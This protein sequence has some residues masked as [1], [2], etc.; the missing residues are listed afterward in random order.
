MGVSAAATCAGLVR[1]VG[2][3]LTLSSCIIVLAIT[4]VPHHT[5]YSQDIDR[6][7]E[8][9]DLGFTNP[10]NV[11]ARPAGMAG[12]YVAAGN[13]VHMLV[14]NPAGLARIKRIELSLGLQQQRSSIALQYYGNPNSIDVRDGGMDGASLAW[15]LP[16]YQGSFTLAFGVYRVYSSVFDLHY[17][18]VNQSTKTFDNYLV[19]QMGSIYSYNLGFGVDLAPTLSGG[20]TFFLLD[21]TIDRLEQFDFT[22]LN[23]TP[24]TSV[25]VKEDVTG[26]LTGVGGRIG[27]QLFF[28]KMIVGGITFTPPVWARVKGSGMAEITEH[29][30]NAP[31]SFKQVPVS[32]DDDYILPFRLDFGAAVMFKRFL[33]EFDFGYS[34]WTEAAIERKRFR[35]RETLEPTFREVF[36]YKLGAEYTFYRLPLRVRA[37]YAYLPYPLAYLQNDRIDENALTKAS[38][39]RERQL[40]AV[41]LGGLIGEVLTIDASVSYTDGKRTAP[42]VED[43]RST[44]RFVLTVSYRF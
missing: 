18:G 32:Y 36:E 6:T 13:D 42:A 8:F 26:D 40:L 37:G 34:D 15:P 2:G 22:Y 41:G 12:A 39:E 25:F 4:V 28:H 16:T 24:Q 30:D 9:E 5:A 10:V 7:V 31:D 29:R 1:R 23:F 14:Y 20:L 27:V 19:Q 44:Y 35:N 43:E 17:S 3:A 11:G 33:L 21:G 38:V